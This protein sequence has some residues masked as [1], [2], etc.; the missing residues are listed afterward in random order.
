MLEPDPFYKPLP[1]N[2]NLLVRKRDYELVSGSTYLQKDDESY[3]QSEKTK[4]NQLK[5]LQNE[6]DSV[7]EN[8]EKKL[9]ELIDESD[10]LIEEVK[11][12]REE[13]EAKN[14]VDKKL[15]NIRK[16]RIQTRNEQEKQFK[17]IQQKLIS[18]K[19]SKIVTKKSKNNDIKK[20]EKFL[21]PI[22][23]EA[24]LPFYRFINMLDA[25]SGKRTFYRYIKD[26]DERKKQNLD[27]PM[28]Y[29]CEDWDE[30]RIANNHLGQS[31]LK[32]CKGWLNQKTPTL[33]LVGVKFRTIPILPKKPKSQ[34]VEEIIEQAFNYIPEHKR[35]SW[36]R[37][38]MENSIFQFLL[39]NATYG[40][41]QLAANEL[42][43]PLKDLIMSDYVNFMFAQFCAVK[44]IKPKSNAYAAGIQGQ[45]LQYRI[46]S[47]VYTGQQQSKWLMGCK[48]WFKDVEYKDTNDIKVKEIQWRDKER[49]NIEEQLVEIQSELDIF[50]SQIRNNFTEN[51]AAPALT[52]DQNRKLNTGTFNDKDIKQFFETYKQYYDIEDEIKKQWFEEFQGVFQDKIHGELLHETMDNEYDIILNEW[53]DRV[54]F[55]K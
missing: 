36:V 6:L 29:G 30:F 25:E 18:K 3:D 2:P 31:L 7:D 8:E 12:E 34:A 51:L 53:P 50:V 17:E 46:S 14:E 4:Q 21:E 49:E 5:R 28:Q 55:K 32:A 54:L 47:G 35:P 40:A 23:K 15:E 52:S 33:N 27:I 19:Q 26:E 16:Q 1:K 11:K 24:L 48:I 20:L 9:Q 44:F 37:S 45:D 39:Q 42:G 38:Q 41:L 43:F 13:I 10:S 22:F